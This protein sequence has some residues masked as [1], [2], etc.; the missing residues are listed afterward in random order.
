[1]ALCGPLRARQRPSSGDPGGPPP[2]FGPR[3]SPDHESLERLRRSPV[4]GGLQ[5]HP[6]H[7]EAITPPTTP[8]E[9]AAPVESS[10]AAACC[11]A[12]C[13]TTCWLCPRTETSAVGAASP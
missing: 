3:R 2:R 11:A 8:A 1:M 4:T 9:T 7:E 6:P 13:A 5:G 12:A 10:D